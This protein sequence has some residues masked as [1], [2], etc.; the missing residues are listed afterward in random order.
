[1]VSRRLRAPEQNGGVVAEPPLTEAGRWLAANQQ[2]F[3]SST[4]AILGRSMSD[5]RREACRTAVQAARSYLEKAGEPL[6]NFGNVSL[7]LAGHQPELFHPG[8]WVKNFAL[9]GLA[10]AHGATPV[11][12]IVDSDTAKSTALRLPTT[13]PQVVHLPF[14]HWSGEVPY[15]ERPVNDERLFA[16]YHNGPHQFGTIGDL[17]LYWRPFGKRHAAKQPAPPCWASVW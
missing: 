15:E 10:R 6:P 9:H 1:M 7:L 16:S 12:L 14:D 13:Q 8:V 2:R 17:F 11:N 5:L 4:F 3:A